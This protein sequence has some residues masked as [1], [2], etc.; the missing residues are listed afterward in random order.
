[1]IL[2]QRDCGTL[3]LR[4]SSPLIDACEAMKRCASSDSDISS[5]NSATAFLRAERRVLGEVG[6]QRRLAHRRPRGEDDQVA[7]LEAAGDRVEVLEARRRAGD[8]LA[9]AARASR[10][11]RAR[12]RA[13]RRSRGSPCGESSWATSRIERSAMSTSSRGG[14]SWRVDA[15][16]GSR[17][18]RAAAGAASRSRGRS[19]RTGGRCRRRGREPASRS[20]AARPPT[21]S[22]WPACLRCS[23]SVSAS[24]GSPPLWRSSIAWKIEPVA[25]RGR[26][27]RAGGARR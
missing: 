17:R 7:G 1:M 15:A 4:R 18:T 27:P 6:H 10:A 13:R 14:A 19:A 12:R 11:C 26:S 21:A 5:E 16:P 9:L 22:S 8:R 3:P 23:T 24:T 25:P 2:P 20:I